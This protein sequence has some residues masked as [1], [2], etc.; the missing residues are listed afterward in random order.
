MQR[1]PSLN[2]HREVQQSTLC[3]RDSHS[4][5]CMS[6][7]G[8][9][10]C[11]MK[12]ADWQCSCCWHGKVVSN[13]LPAQL[14]ACINCAH[15]A[16]GNFGVRPLQCCLLCPVSLK[17]VGSNGLKTVVSNGLKTVACK[18]NLSAILNP[19]ELILPVLK[20]SDGFK[21]VLVYN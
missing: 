7:S 8:Q 9:C 19:S 17:T 16:E 14:Y 3:M 5:L 15:K 18:L 20:L 12:A 6:I 1:C 10:C 13:L 4:L 21:S 11:A 2:A